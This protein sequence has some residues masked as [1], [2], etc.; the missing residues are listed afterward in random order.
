MIQKDRMRIGLGP[1]IPD[2]LPNVSGIPNKVPVAPENISTGKIT[3]PPIQL[4]KKIDIS[5]QPGTYKKISILE[6]I[7]G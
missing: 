3:F 7:F 5:K 4:P 2:K 1:K 6:R